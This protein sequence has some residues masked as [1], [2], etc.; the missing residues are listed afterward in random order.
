M[1]GKKQ[2]KNSGERQK[3]KEEWENGAL[4]SCLFVSEVMDVSGAEGSLEK[5]HPACQSLSLRSV[6][7]VGNCGEQ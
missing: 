2:G 1:K 4:S 6:V 7:A 5:G 3:G